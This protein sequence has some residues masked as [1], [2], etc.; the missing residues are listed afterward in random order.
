MHRM[1]SK[2]QL[3]LL[4]GP[5]LTLRQNPQAPPES[6]KVAKSKTRAS[7]K[8]AAGKGVIRS[9]FGMK[10][11]PMRVFWRLLFHGPLNKLILRCEHITACIVKN[12]SKLGYQHRSHHEHAVTWMET[13]QKQLHKADIRLLRCQ[14]HVHFQVIQLLPARTT[15]P[16]E[17]LQHYSPLQSSLG[18]ITW[19][20]AGQTGRQ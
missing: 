8:A 15:A 1:T 6:Q 12:F 17:D 19:G 2:D 11:R 18:L 3:S 9:L 10:M 5:S 20:S 7:Q 4:S 14:L 13:E 16:E